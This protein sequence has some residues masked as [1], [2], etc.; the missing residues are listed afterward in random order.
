FGGWLQGKLIR[1]KMSCLSVGGHVC[2]GRVG[3][4]RTVCASNVKERQ[5][6]IVCELQAH[7]VPA[8]L[9]GLELVREQFMVHPTGAAHSKFLLAQFDRTGSRKAR[10]RNIV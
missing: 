5:L 4:N 2:S 10:E 7:P 6:G 9:V 3:I 8:S 1:A